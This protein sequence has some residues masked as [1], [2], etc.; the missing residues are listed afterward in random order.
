VPLFNALFGSKPLYLAS[1]LYRMMQRVFRYLERF[2]R[3]SRVWQTDGQ[4]RS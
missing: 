4:T 3:D 1:S 2:R